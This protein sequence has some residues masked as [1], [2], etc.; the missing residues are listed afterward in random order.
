MQKQAKLKLG[1]NEPWEKEVL[2]FESGR[3]AT[4]RFRKRPRYDPVSLTRI[5]SG[6]R[7]RI[8]GGKRSCTWRAP[9][10]AT[11]TTAV[12][13]G[14]ATATTSQMRADRAKPA[15]A[16]TSNHT[17]WRGPKWRITAKASRKTAAEAEAS[18]INEISM[19]RWI[20]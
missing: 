8:S 12:G 10:L 5:S 7:S 3:I 20:F 17:A 15:S 16:P 2:D 9:S 19:M 14:V 11:S 6:R 18:A 4:G 13:A 1:T